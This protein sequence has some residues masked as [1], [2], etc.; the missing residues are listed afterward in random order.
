MGFIFILVRY[1]YD[2]HKK[3]NDVIKGRA[4]KL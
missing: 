1:I 4:K 2:N 3:D